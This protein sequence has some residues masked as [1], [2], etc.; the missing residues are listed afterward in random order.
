MIPVPIAPHLEAYATWTTEVPNISTLITNYGKHWLGGRKFSVFNF[1]L[2]SV[3]QYCHSAASHYL[4]HLVIN[5]WLHSMSG[6]ISIS[7]HL[8]ND[9]LDSLFNMLLKSPTCH[10]SRITTLHNIGLGQNFS[11]WPSVRYFLGTIQHM[12]RFSNIRTQQAL[13][14]TFQGWTYRA[15]TDVCGLD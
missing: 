7:W 5:T 10:F 3:L 1:S 11:A 15:H 6:S 12:Y 2:H 8:I 14:T 13:G 4:Q 9:K